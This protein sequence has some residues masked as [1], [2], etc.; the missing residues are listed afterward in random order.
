MRAPNLLAA[1][2]LRP[3]LPLIMVGVIP[4]AA[5]ASAQVA[6]SSA[7]AYESQA[8]ETTNKQRTRRDLRSLRTNACLTRFADRQAVRMADQRRIFHQDL[9]P[10]LRRC[11]LGRVGENVAVGYPSGKSVVKDGWMRSSGHRRNILT[12]GFRIVAVGAAQ[13]AGGRWYTAQVFGR[14]R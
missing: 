12:R 6:A 5:P 9:S 4:M 1:T 3:L 13:D 14:R 8:V 2:V 10:V 7:A 11:G